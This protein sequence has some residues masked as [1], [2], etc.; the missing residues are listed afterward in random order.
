MTRSYET[1]PKNRAFTFKWQG[2]LLG[3]CL[4]WRIT[5]FLKATLYKFIGEEV[6][7]HFVK[8]QDPLVDFSS[9]HTVCC[10]WEDWTHLLHKWFWYEKSFFCHEAKLSVLCPQNNLTVR[11]DFV[12]PNWND[13]MWSP[14]LYQRVILLEIQIL[15]VNKWV[16]TWKWVSNFSQNHPLS[17]YMF[18]SKAFFTQLCEF[19]S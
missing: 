7:S 8:P 4:W 5:W 6:M 19:S 9:F 3:V 14:S 17:Y 2:V 10:C 11:L 12:D 18:H 16:A 13:S 15:S 1:I